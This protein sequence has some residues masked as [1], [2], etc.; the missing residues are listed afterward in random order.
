VIAAARKLELSVQQA[1]ASMIAE[2]VWRFSQRVKSIEELDAGLDAIAKVVTPEMAQAVHITRTNGDCLTV[3][4]GARAG[5]VLSFVAKS[6]EPPYFVSLGDPTANGA[7]PYCV[8]S[9]HH[10]EALTRSV[11]P[12]EEARKALREFVCQSSGLPRDVVWAEV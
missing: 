5:S 12:E 9:D 7:I 1:G 8:E 4:L 11:I 3:V 6:G 10:S 2:I